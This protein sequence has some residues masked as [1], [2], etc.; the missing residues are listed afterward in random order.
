MRLL[1]Y[2]VKNF[3]SIDDSGWIETDEVTALIGTNESGKTNVL[4]PLWKLNP[5]KEGAI[6]PTAD[7]P[8]KHYNTFR[9]QKPKP[10]FIRAVFELD[11]ELA[12]LVSEKTGMATEAIREV[13]VARRFDS[14]YEVDFPNALPARS[15]NRE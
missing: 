3:R 10:I 9:H 14:E 11:D 15:L 2:R 13:E 6:V 7:Y 4:L 8:R 12:G 1:R 5:A